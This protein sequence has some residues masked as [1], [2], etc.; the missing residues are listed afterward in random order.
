MERCDTHLKRRV[1]EITSKEE[2][3]A[4]KQQKIEEIESRADDTLQEAIRN[5]GKNIYTLQD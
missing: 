3:L 2:A 5:A 4:I 1:E